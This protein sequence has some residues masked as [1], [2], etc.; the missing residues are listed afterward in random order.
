MKKGLCRC[1]NALTLLS[2]QS[3]RPNYVTP[4]II[5]RKPTCA[6]KRQAFSRWSLMAFLHPPSPNTVS[7]SRVMRKRWRPGCIAI[8]TTDL[9]VYSSRQDE[10]ASP[11]FPPVDPARAREAVQ[12]VLYRSPVLYGHDRHTWTLQT[13]QETVDWMKSLSVPAVCKALKRFKLAYKR[14]RAHVHSP[15]LLYNEKVDLLDMIKQEVRQSAGEKVLLYEDE[16]TAYLRPVV[17]RSYRK[18]SDAGQKATGA[19]GDKVRLAACVDAVTGRVLWRRRDSYNVKEMYRFFYYV[20]QQYPDAQVIYVALDNWP[21]H[22]HPYV[23]DHLAKM[24]GGNRIVFVWLPTYAPWTNPTEKYWRKL[25]R[26]WL[27]FHPF[28]GD[29]KWFTR[30]LDS[31]LSRHSQPSKSLLHEIGV[32]PVLIC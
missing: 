10:A 12:E 14:G 32:L 2:Q 4:V 6:K 24:K 25:V 5:T 17:A 21:I 9:P 30:E 1:Q 23:K 16:F 8:S 31:W 29:K 22:F 28:A 27:S 11:L 26:E 19:T 3:N 20:N 18:R 13:L 15:D 7:S